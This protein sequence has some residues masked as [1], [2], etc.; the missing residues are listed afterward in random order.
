MLYY[1]R[2]PFRKITEGKSKVNKS[3]GSTAITGKCD[4]VINAEPDK[5]DNEVVKFE[6]VKTEPVIA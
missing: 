4:V 2:S 5:N 1:C 3:R 6:V